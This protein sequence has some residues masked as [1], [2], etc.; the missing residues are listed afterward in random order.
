MAIK[1]I[2][3]LVCD[4]CGSSKDVQEWA[5]VNPERDRKAGALCSKHHRG[6]N[7][8]WKAWEPSKRRR[9]DYLVLGGPDDVPPA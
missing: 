6:L 9:G 7:N 8:L 3:T 5:V 4:I 1:K 2:V